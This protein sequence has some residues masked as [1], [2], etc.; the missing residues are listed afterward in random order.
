MSRNDFLSKFA[1]ILNDENFDVRKID[2]SNVFRNRLFFFL[3]TMG[4]GY[5]SL[6]IL[7]RLVKKDE[8]KYFEIIE[9]LK[10]CKLLKSNEE[11]KKGLDEFIYYDKNIGINKCY[12]IKYHNILRDITSVLYDDKDIVNCSCN[13]ESI[14]I[15]INIPL[16]RNNIGEKKELVAILSGKA[17]IKHKFHIIEKSK[18]EENISKSLLIVKRIDKVRRKLELGSFPL[19]D[20][21]ML[22]SEFLESPFITTETLELLK[23]LYFNGYYSSESIKVIKILNKTLDLD[24][25]DENILFVESKFRCFDSNFVK[26]IVDIPLG[27]NGDKLDFIINKIVNSKFDFYEPFLGTIYSFY[28]RNN[29]INALLKY[30]ELCDNYD[31]DIYKYGFKKEDKIKLNIYINNLKN[32]GYKIILN[33]RI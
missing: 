1:R 15:N 6:G 3:K 13:Y 28:K 18:S 4:Y 2:Y 25:N 33:K 11:I 22:E 31:I 12:E 26:R 19:Y 16:N 21:I 20:L 23:K 24:V 10:D 8:K 29:D 30:I 32:L 17:I 14:S 27:K 9:I 7:R 5:G